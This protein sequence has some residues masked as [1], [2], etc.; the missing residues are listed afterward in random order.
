MDYHSHQKKKAYV[1]KEHVLP[2]GF[3][4]YGRNIV[5][6]DSKVQTSVMV[7]ADFDDDWNPGPEG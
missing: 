5:E 2:A 3:K 6:I 4:S 7:E 1:F